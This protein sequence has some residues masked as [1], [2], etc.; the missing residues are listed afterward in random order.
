VFE[1]VPKDS[2]FGYVVELRQGVGVKSV[3]QVDD[4]EFGGVVVEVNGFVFLQ[5]WGDFCDGVLPKASS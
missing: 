3:G 1:L 4:L 5:R 2:H